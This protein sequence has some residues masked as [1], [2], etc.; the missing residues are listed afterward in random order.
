MSDAPPIPH[1]VTRP[2][3]VRALPLIE[4]TSLGGD[5][6]LAAQSIEVLTIEDLIG[7]SRAIRDQPPGREVRMGV[8]RTGK[9]V[10]LA[11]IWSGPEG[12]LSPR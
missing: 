5:I 3:I 6:I 2:E 8:L 7:A 1:D 9:V 11:T 10:E 12:V 4:P